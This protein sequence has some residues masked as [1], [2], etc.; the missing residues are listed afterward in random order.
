MR[1]TYLGYRVVQW[2]SQQLPPAVAFRWGDFIAD[3]Q[4]RCSRRHRAAVQ[5]NL[6]VATGTPQPWHSRLTREVFRNFSRYLIEFFTI[7][8]VAHPLVAC[9]GLEHVR[10][11]HQRGRGV[12][13]LSAHLGNWEVGGIL[14]QRMGFPVTAVVLPHEDPRMDRLFNAQ[15]RRNGIDVIPLGS[16]ATSQSI[17]ALRA[18]KLLGLLGD[19]DFTD[20]GVKVLFCGAPVILPR[21][22]A[23]LSVRSQAPVVPTFLIREGPWRF[24]LCCEAAIWPARDQKPAEAVQA[25]THAYATVLGRYVRQYPEQWPIFRSVF[26]AQA[27][28]PH[29]DATGVSPWRNSVATRRAFK[30]ATPRTPNLWCGGSPSTRSGQELPTARSLVDAR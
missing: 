14:L 25:L 21:G 12:I 22:P 15:R 10:S 28:P 18:G 1:H 24:R 27:S 29:Q 11:A 16:H 17:R 4:W 13:L 6:S 19:Q 8:Q 23:I 9:Q 3:V 20:K 5:A 7:H 26:T 30:E 2:V